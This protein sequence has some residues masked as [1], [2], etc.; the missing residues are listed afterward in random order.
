MDNDAIKH[1]KGFSFF[2]K[3]PKEKIL[4]MGYIQCLKSQDNFLSEQT[5]FYI[6]QQYAITWW[7][8]LKSN[9]RTRSFWFMNQSF[10]HSYQLIHWKDPTQNNDMSL[11]QVSLFYLINFHEC[12][13]GSY[14]TSMTFLWKSPVPFIC[15]YLKNF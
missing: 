14:D 10:Y 12:A 11:S 2:Y 15:K 1:Q 3:K 7:A 13:K 5:K 8:R 9:S 4:L 6:I